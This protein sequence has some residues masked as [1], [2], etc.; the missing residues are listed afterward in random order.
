MP[1]RLP[2]SRIARAVATT[3]VAA[4]AWKVTE[5]APSSA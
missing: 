1:A 4:S 2:R 3:S 5:N